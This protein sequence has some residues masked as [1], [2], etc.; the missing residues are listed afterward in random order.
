MDPVIFTG[1]LRMHEFRLERPLEFERMAGERILEEAAVGPQPDWLTDL[2]ILF[3]FAVSI[4]LF[5]LV[6]I[7]LGQFYY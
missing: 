7:L 2:G 3:G 1:R 4:G 5:L 6:L